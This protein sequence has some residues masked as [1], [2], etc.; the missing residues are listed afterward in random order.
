M[1][2]VYF[3]LR[4]LAAQ[5]DYEPSL[6]IKQPWQAAWERDFTWLSEVASK[7][8]LGMTAG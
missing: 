5:A 6:R 3:I 1:Q 7:H 4:Q 8:Y 2:Q